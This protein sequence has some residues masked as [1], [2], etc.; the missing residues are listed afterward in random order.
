MNI[1]IYIQELM[2]YVRTD[3][4]LIELMKLGAA[5]VLFLHI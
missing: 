4:L 3:R 1:C 2:Q 5:Q